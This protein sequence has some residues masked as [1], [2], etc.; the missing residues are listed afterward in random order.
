[1]HKKILEAINATKGF[2]QKNPNHCYDLYDHTM[3]VMEGVGDDDEELLL[4]AA[5]HDIGKMECFTEEGGVRK[6][7][8][9]AKKSAEIAEHLL[10]SEGYPEEQIKRICW[11][12]AEHESDISSTK[13]M[14]K[15]LDTA[16]EEQVRKLIK[17]RRADIMAQAPAVQ[18]EHLAVVAKSEATLAE[19]LANSQSIKLTVKDLAIT[20][21]DLALLGLKGPAI[22]EAQR[23]LVEKIEGGELENSKEALLVFLENRALV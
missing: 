3:K 21:R 8:G 6:F 7:I 10:R 4:A 1:M 17:L 19:I 22:G 11:L 20:G 5:L 15:R 12:V 23:K 13:S 16:G 18:Q 2:D 9:H 14:K